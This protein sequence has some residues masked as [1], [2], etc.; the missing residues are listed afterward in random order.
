LLLLL[1]VVVVVLLTHCWRWWILFGPQDVPEKARRGGWVMPA[2]DPV[3][4]ASDLWWVTPAP[5]HSL[6][7][8]APQ[9]SLW[10]YVTSTTTKGY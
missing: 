5:L 6:H 7:V 2:P 4:Q 9:G 8:A 3:F 1:L 10:G